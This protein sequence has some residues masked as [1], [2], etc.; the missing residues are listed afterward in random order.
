MARRVLH[1]S[2]IMPG[3]PR[4][5]AMLG[6]VGIALGQPALAQRSALPSAFDVKPVLKSSK[7]ADGDV[8]QLPKTDKPE[9]ISVIGTLQPGG[10]TA[11]HQH[12]IPVYVYVME[13][14]LE[15]Q[16]D[17]AEARHYKAGEA[18]LESVGKWHQAFNK[19]S[20]PAR[21]LVVF[22]GEEGKPTTVNAP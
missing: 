12:P 3:R 22:F 5:G 6:L 11:R 10:R 4:L 1:P 20:T 21:I 18:F 9:I 7:T 19:G 16:T 2:R 15:V 17:G 14:D 13:G 8:L